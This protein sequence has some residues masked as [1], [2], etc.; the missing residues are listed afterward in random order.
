M[1]KK[2]FIFILS[3]IFTFSVFG[4]R[5]YFWR[6]RSHP[7]DCTSLT[8]GKLRDL[9]FEEDDEVLYKCDAEDGTCDTPSEW[10]LVTPS[11]GSDGQLQYN[12]G[13]S[14]GGASDF[15]YD[16]VNGNVGIGTTE[17]S[18]I[19][20]IASNGTDD[21]LRLTNNTSGDIL[22]VDSSGDMAVNTDTLYVDAANGR[23]G[24]GTTSPQSKL[25][26]NG[27][28]AIGD[29]TTNY[30]EFGTNGLLTLYGTA[31]VRKNVEIAIGSIKPPATH[32]ASWAD[33]G[34]AGAWEFSDGTTETVILE[35][36]LP[37]DIDR[38]ENVVVDIMWASPSTT[39][40]CVW[41]L[42][43]LMR[44]EDEAINAAA[45]DTLRQTVAPSSTAN[46]LVI[47]SFTIPAT[48]ISDTDKILILKLDRIGGDTDD[49][50]GDVAYLSSMNFNYISDKLGESTT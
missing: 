40:N 5:W 34:I 23:V 27:S 48:D 29:L 36:P 32:P 10:K 14:F 22:T 44:G 1:R 26:V 7:T 6:Y 46:G 11:A 16:D 33:L 49:T 19:L 50:L 42:S 31:R 3:F 45:D 47:T 8:D 24:I 38:T 20:E 28:A 25:D 21:Y 37:L 9:C 4:A 13:G 39:G 30:A 15:Y 17:P 35:I 2:I 41:E 12:D 18:S 43:Y